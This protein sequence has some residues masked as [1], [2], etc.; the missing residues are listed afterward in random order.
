[1]G[2][3]IEDDDRPRRERPVG[4]V[5]CERQPATVP[6]DQLGNIVFVTSGS[7]AVE[8]AIKLARSYHRSKGDGQKIKLIAREIAYHGTTLGALAIHVVFPLAPPRM[9]PSASKTKV[10]TS[11]SAPPAV[12]NSSSRTAAVSSSTMAC[13]IS[14]LSRWACTRGEAFAR[15]V[16]RMLLLR[17]RVVNQSPRPGTIKRR[18]FPVKLAVGR[19]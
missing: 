18:N 13:R 3:L 11:A 10:L 2:D 8:S 6:D 4:D 17:G 1:M 5:E 19:G 14:L 9:M 12:S 7:E 16:E 15:A